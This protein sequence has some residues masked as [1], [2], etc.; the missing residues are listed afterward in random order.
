MLNEGSYVPGIHPAGKTEMNQ[1]VVLAIGNVLLS[2]DGV[3]AKVLQRLRG[4][5]GVPADAR[6]VDGGT[7]SFPLVGEF[8][9]CSG[10]VV[11]DASRLGAPPGTVRRFDGDAMDRQLSRSG[12]SVHEVG[13]ADLL[14]IAR[15]GGQ[16]PPR[17]ALVGIE[18]ACVDWGETLSPP[19]QAAVPR[20]ATLITELLQCW[21]SE[22]PRA[23]PWSPVEVSLP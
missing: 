13:L 16:M 23:R 22:A 8:Q 4:A 3:G 12:R 14:D 9:D 1:F 18:P 20:A 6:L 5:P 7:M 21:R 2:D 11:V 17:R 15:L 19:V 10:L